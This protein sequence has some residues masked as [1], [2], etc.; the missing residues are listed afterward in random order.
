MM[1]SSLKTQ[2]I[3][4]IIMT[5]FE[6]LKNSEGLQQYCFVNIVLLHVVFENKAPQRWDE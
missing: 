5:F 1:Y 4:I 2:L 3:K 6:D